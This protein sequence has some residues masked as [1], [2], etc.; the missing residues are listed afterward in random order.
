ME[1][2][3]EYSERVREGDRRMGG[4]ARPPSR[5][6]KRYEAIHTYCAALGATY[7]YALDIFA[8]LFVRVTAS[9]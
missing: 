2:S 3:H 5:I 6:I 7:E 8:A 1:K 4:L 9:L